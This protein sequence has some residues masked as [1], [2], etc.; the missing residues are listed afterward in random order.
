K[1]R[2][3]A[4]TLERAIV[5]GGTA[6]ERLADARLYVLV[7]GS[8]CATGLE[9]TVRQAAEGGAQVIQLREK[10]LSDREL[11]ERARQ[12]RRLARAAGV[13]FILDEPPH[14]SPPVE[15]GRGAPGP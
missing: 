9:R 5:M 6:R 10:G 8:L 12:V 14:I 3:R 1:L 11:L 15:A 13:L 4:Y 7:T 2:Y